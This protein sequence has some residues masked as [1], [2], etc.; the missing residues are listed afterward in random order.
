MKLENFKHSKKISLKYIE[1]VVYFTERTLS[2]RNSCSLMD[3]TCKALKDGSETVLCYSIAEGSINWKDDDNEEGREEKTLRARIHK[4]PVGAALWSF[5]CPGFGQVYNCQ[6]VLGFTLVVLE[7]IVNFHSHLNLSLLYT[8]H[9]QFHQ[10]YRVARFDWGLFYPSLWGFSMWQAYNRAREIN[11]IIEGNDKP[12][13]AKRVG[14]FFGLV[15]GMNLGLILY[16]PE[17]FGHFY[18]SPPANG[19]IGGLLGAFTGLTVERILSRI[20]KDKD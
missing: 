12:F 17:I 13:K 7:F 20:Q 18:L 5:A 16:G 11:H 3:K 14:F 1:R 6:Y 4:S 2:L 10:S 9:G 8:F 15:A 19:I